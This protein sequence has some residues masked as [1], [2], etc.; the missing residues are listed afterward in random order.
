M[1]LK[2]DI[3]GYRIITSPTNSGGGMCVWAFAS[4]GSR[5]YFIKEF[6]HPKWPLPESMGSEASK[7]VRRA[8]C[9]EFERRHREVMGRLRDATTTPG[10][11]NLVTAVDFFRFGT[12]FYKV[13]ERIATESLTS[14]EDLSTRERAVIFRTLVLSLQM[15]HR[16]NIVHG[17][18]KPANVLIQRVPGGSLQT[19]KLID[20][21]DSYLSGE[22]PPRDQIVGDSLYAAPE[23]FGY[24]M[25]DELVKPGML[26]K[27]SDI[28]ALAL[29]FHH[30]LTGELPAYDRTRFSAPGQAV[31][32]RQRLVPDPRLNSRF[33]ALFG[34]MTAT[35]PAE[36][37]AIDQVF[38]QL[39]NDTMLS[40]SEPSVARSTGASRV[41]TNLTGGTIRAGGGA[42]TGT[43]KAADSARTTP[44]GSRVRINMPGKKEKTKE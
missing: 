26:T 43:R 32:A 37:P 8:E 2:E 28:F 12:T 24:T 4:K 22:P 33:T 7:V 10:G 42:G 11:G 38:N 15:L 21:D 39:K 25:N 18:L 31:N 16:K 30:Y 6:L 14:L 1:K 27:A 23:W 19:A 36:R 20:F 9:N 29:L 5:D 13:T 34:Q 41:M 3:K 35:K 17:D 40:V 44:A